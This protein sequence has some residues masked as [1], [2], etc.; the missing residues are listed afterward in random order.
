MLPTFGP[1][2]PTL[3]EWAR[4]GLLPTVDE[5]AAFIAD[6]GPAYEELEDG[7]VECATCTG[8][9]YLL[10]ASG[11]VRHYR[12]QDCGMTFSLTL[13]ETAWE[14]GGT[15]THPPFCTGHTASGSPCGRE[16][17]HS[18]PHHP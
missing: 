4:R 2:F 13:T 5:H 17:G 9:A 16:W 14:K 10:G 1:I 3:A 12:C 15:V 8:D 18:G 11:R 6:M 7:G